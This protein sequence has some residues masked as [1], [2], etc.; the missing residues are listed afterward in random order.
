[1]VFIQN[2]WELA[3]RGYYNGVIFH[4]II[5]D[6]MIQGGDPTGT[7]KGGE[8]IYGYFLSFL[9]LRIAFVITVSDLSNFFEHAFP[10]FNSILVFLLFT[11]YGFLFT[12]QL[13]LA[14][15]R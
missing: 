15:Q 5:K 1:M 7:G 9:L 4:R 10:F 12:R 6:F 8:S 2:F 3:R 13:I 14:M 11:S